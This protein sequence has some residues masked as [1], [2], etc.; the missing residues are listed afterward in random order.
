MNSLSESQ[1]GV[2]DKVPFQ[3]IVILG[4]LKETM[5]FP[6]RRLLLIERKKLFDYCD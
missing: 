1:N 6:K 5:R 4:T 2:N 3:S